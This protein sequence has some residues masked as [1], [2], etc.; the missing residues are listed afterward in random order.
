MLLL[1]VA[2]GAYFL[3][4]IERVQGD[5]EIVAFGDSLVEGIGSE[6][7][8]GFVPM[9]EEMAGRPI[10]NLGRRGDTTADALAR[11]GSVLREKPDVVIVLLGGNDL[12]Q[13]VPA[14]ETA[15]N[16]ALIN[17]ELKN[18]GAKV[19]LVKLDILNGIEGNSA[20]MSRDGIH[21]NDRGYR[22]MAERIY[23]ALRKLLR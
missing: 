5:I 18:A 1:A 9:L 4:H 3:F 13:H 14:G 8:G 12:L 22:L 23:P 10:L 6:Q 15:R 2:L 21:P 19:L 7:G 16:L 11:I 20:L 17:A